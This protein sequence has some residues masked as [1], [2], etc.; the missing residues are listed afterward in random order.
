MRIVQ[1]LTLTFLLSNCQTKEDQ[2]IGHWHSIPMEDGFYWTL[3]VTDS[4]SQ[5]NK[6]D[7]FSYHQVFERVYNHEFRE[8]LVI[9]YESYVDF[10]VKND[11]LFIDENLKFVRT[12]DPNYL[13]DHF[14]NSLVRLNLPKPTTNSK[15]K[16]PRPSQQAHLFIGPPY[17]LSESYYY[18]ADSTCFQTVDFI[19]TSLTDLE[20]FVRQEDDKLS[21]VENNWLIIHADSTTSQ[22]TLDTLLSV[23]EPLGI[24]NGFIISRYNYEHDTLEFEDL[25]VGNKPSANMPVCILPVSMQTDRFTAHSA[26]FISPPSFSSFW[27]K[28]F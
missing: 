8:I 4:T 28:T 10:E 19:A 7:Q 16:L 12:E 22:A 25:T 21:E 6:H 2:L 9:D 13:R 14:P 18:N 27:I 1:L 11:T 17:Q 3:D 26:T 20:Y 15:T 24:L 23:V 5:V